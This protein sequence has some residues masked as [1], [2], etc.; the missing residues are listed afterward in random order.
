M[1]RAGEVFFPRKELPC[2]LFDMV[3][4]SMKWIYTY[5][6]TKTKMLYRVYA[7]WVDSIQE[8]VNEKVLNFRVIWGWGIC[9]GGVKKKKGERR[10]YVII[11]T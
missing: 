3:W 9:S 1:L 11:L 5:K 2:L 8:Q 6:Y 10:N 4:S 7:E